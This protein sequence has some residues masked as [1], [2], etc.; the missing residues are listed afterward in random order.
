[1]I[2]L[3]VLPIYIT[4]IA[5]F[6]ISTNG[7]EY[8]LDINYI[9]FKT[10]PVLALS[11]LTYLGNTAVNEKYRKIQT[12]AL[13]FGAIGDFLIAFLHNNISGLVI[14]AVAFG[15]GHMFYLKTFYRKLKHLYIPL[16]I[17]VVVYG[18]VINQLFLVPKLD[19]DLIS[20][21][22]LMIYS[23]ILAVPLLISGSMYLG[24]CIEYENAQAFHKLRFA[25]FI[26]FF[27]SDSVLLLSNTGHRFPYSEVLI[28][29]TY[30]AAQYLILCALHEEGK[31][32]DRKKQ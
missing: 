32:K 5:F 27:I 1:M 19:E 25:G 28:L 15:I 18:A 20:T 22:I 12:T 16:T 10:L 26:F 29:T 8:T 21:I 6:G 2:H 30:F 17:P 9:F 23:A 7:F 4:L 3:N 31:L 24:G 14:G 13:L 11:V